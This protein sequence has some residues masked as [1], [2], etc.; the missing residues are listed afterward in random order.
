MPPRILIFPVWLVEPTVI[1]A[2]P[3]LNTAPAPLHKEAGN[4]IAQVTAVALLA[5]EVVLMPIV[6]VAVNGMICRLPLYVL[7]R[8]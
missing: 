3:S 2:K 8:I 5:H 4:E 1:A 7:D 6:F